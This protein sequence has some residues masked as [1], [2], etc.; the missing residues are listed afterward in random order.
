MGCSGPP[1]VALSLL[2]ASCNKGTKE[3]RWGPR[4][5]CVQNN[6]G[7]PKLDINLTHAGVLLAAGLAAG[8]CSTKTGP[9]ARLARPARIGAYTAMLLDISDILCSAFE[10]DIRPQCVVGRSLRPTKSPISVIMEEIGNL[11]TLSQTSS[12]FH[13]HRTTT[14]QPITKTWPRLRVHL[15]GS[16]SPARTK[17]PI[18][19]GRRHEAL[20]WLFRRSSIRDD[21][22][23]L[24]SGVLGHSSPQCAAAPQYCG[25]P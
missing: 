13:A 7:S 24:S 9:P 15:S 6:R 17:N 11:C 22:C 4:E 2:T 19:P 8:A 16:P 10:S 14:T 1:V 3:L 25:F 20:L 18:D 23:P 5:T 21:R 12:S